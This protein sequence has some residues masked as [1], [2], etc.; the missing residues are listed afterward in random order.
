MEHLELGVWDLDL[1]RNRFEVSPVWRRLRG[2]PEDEEISQD[3]ADW[4]ADV[5]P[6]DRE[7]LQQKC[8]QQVDGDLDGFRHKF[9]YKHR[10][11]HWIWLLC[12][13]KV[14]H[15]GPDGRALRIIGTDT[16]ITERQ[17]NED[18][19]AK[20]ASKLQLAIEAS[21]MGIWE[22]DPESARVHWDDRML[23]L[24]GLQG[25]RN[26]LPDDIWETFLHPDDY[27]STLE[28]SQECQR[29]NSDFNRDYRIID[30]LGEV[31][32]IRSLS[33]FVHAENGQGKLIGVNIDV[34]SDYERAEELERAR[35]KLEHD[36]R[37]DALTGLANRRLLDE[38]I[39]K[40]F[41][42]VG[43]EDRY[44]VL[45]LDLDF[46]KQIN[47]TLGHAAGDALLVHVALKLRR[48]LADQGLICRVG[49]DEFVVLFEQAPQRDALAKIAEELIEAFDMPMAYQD[50]TVVFGAS[51]GCAIGSGKPNNHSEIFIQ[52][53]TA[54]YAAKSA[55]RSCFR[56][57]SDD[58]R[59]KVHLHLKESQALLDAIA[60]DEITCFYQ[61]QYDANTLE[62]VGAEALVRWDC[63]SK[64]IRTPD[65]FLPLAERAGFLTKIDETVY[66]RVLADQSDW[67]KKGITFPPISLNI[68]KERL[69]SKSLCS[70]VA[71]SLQDH[72]KLA[73]ELLETAFLDQPDGPMMVNLDGLRDLG[74]D[75]QLDDFGSGHSSVVAMKMIKPNRVKIDRRLVSPIGQNPH[76]ISTL[77]SLSMIARLERIGVVVEGIET[78]VHLS[79][80]RSVDCDILQGF[81]LSRPMN[82]EKFEDMLQ[83]QAAPRLK[84]IQK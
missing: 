63:P 71:A 68:S 37:H 57:Y 34:T 31:K 22:F 9:R 79:A 10:D 75:L 50:H 58:I 82:R 49:G 80:I 46:F 64:G 66:N 19:Q 27:Q 1:E 26:K 6:L 17:G 32:H 72:H 83:S 54:L 44:A 48:M 43:P 24:Y 77:Q 4:L 56:F 12:Q 67:A 84:V 41:D 78:N 45:H 13:A 5:H 18:V 20:L 51:I 61:P 8:G 14:M 3:C 42:T 11:G 52:A 81:A 47:D 69:M 74:I 29:T 21:G 28:Y 53:D 16:D 36:S 23:E 70:Q 15:R 65:E 60:N 55:G 59:A 73:F 7:A 38:T 33:R 62:V 30:A 39:A 35:R 76:Q 40:L 25:Q 2:V